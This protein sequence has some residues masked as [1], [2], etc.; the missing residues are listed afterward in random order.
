M[1]SVDIQAL[2][3][4]SDDVDKLNIIR[5]EMKK[6]GAGKD[7][8]EFRRYDGAK[9]H[10][11]LFYT[12]Q[13]LKQTVEYNIT[14]REE[15]RNRDPWWMGAMEG[16]LLLNKFV[17]QSDPDTEVG[18]LE[19]LF[20]TSEAIREAGRPEWMVVAGF[21]HDLGKLWCLMGG[22]GQWDTVGDT[23]PVGAEYSKKI[24]L[25]ESLK[26]NPDFNNPRYNSKYG[27]YSPGCGLDKL[28]MSWGHDEVLYQILKDQSTLPPEALAMIRY[29]SFYPWHFEN[30]YS[31]F[32]NE[33]D[34]AMKPWVKDFNQFDLYS[35]SDS[36]PDVEKLIIR[37]TLANLQSDQQAAVAAAATV[38]LE[39][40]DMIKE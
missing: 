6:P 32:E 3:R 14:V 22:Q 36:P 28:M 5:A 39:Y 7:K 11:R 37:S 25:Y 30:E 19:H 8:A 29:H 33:H 26:E 17:D 23:F 27:I 2:E 24:E 1:T 34:R 18:Q 35:K 12:E 9:D 15:F 16:A 21:V 38:A 13:H 31:H 4:T 10:V 20:Q 40:S